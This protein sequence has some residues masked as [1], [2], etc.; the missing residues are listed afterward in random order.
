M[1]KILL[2]ARQ[3]PALLMVASLAAGPVLADPPEGKGKGKGKGK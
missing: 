3:W 1:K 2:Q